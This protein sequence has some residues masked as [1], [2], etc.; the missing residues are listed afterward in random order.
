[1]A[2]MKPGVVALAFNPS[3]REAEAVSEFQA[4]LV[5]RVS[6]RTA[7]TT[8]R[9]PV[10]KNQKKKKNS[11]YEWNFPTQLKNDNI[12]RDTHKCRDVYC[13]AYLLV[14]SKRMTLSFPWLCV[15]EMKEE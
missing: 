1:M 6:S 2:I 12:F 14:R 10:S 7:K 15:L 5:Y 8:Q 9:N 3:T 4:S 13:F 11:N